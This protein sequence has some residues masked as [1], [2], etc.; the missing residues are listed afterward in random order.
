[1]RADRR[2]VRADTGDI[3]HDRRDLARTF[4]RSPRRRA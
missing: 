3:R 2:E 1:L 4:T